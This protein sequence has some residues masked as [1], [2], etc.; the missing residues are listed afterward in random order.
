MT[1]ENPEEGIYIG[2]TATIVEV[3]SLPTEGCELEFVNQDGTTKALFLLD[4]MTLNF[5][6]S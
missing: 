2:H 4:L 5:V 6:N 3:Y 1:Q